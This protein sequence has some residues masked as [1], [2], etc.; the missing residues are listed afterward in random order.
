VA[1][2]GFTVSLFIGDLAFGD[3]ALVQDAKLGILAGSLVM[4]L[5]GFA[6][7]HLMSRGGGRGQAP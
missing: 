3:A 1:G 2:I 5:A 4:G 6:A 7:L